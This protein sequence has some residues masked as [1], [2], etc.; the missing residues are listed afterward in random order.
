MLDALKHRTAEQTVAMIQRTNLSRCQG[1]LRIV[2]FEL[3]AA[4]AERFEVGGARRGG[5]ARARVTTA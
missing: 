3:G 4:F 5:M 1:T 2:V